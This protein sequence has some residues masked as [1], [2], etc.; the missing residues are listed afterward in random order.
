M[1]VH[2]GNPQ[3]DGDE[4]PKVE[5]FKEEKDDMEVDIKEDENEPELTFPYE[6][7]DPLNLWPLASDLEPEDVIEFEDTTESEDVTVPA[8]DI[9]SL[10]GRITSISRRLR[11]R[12]TAHA[13][14]EKKG[15]AKDKYY[16]KLILDLGNEMGSSVEEG[17]VAMKNLVR[18]LGN[19]EERAECN[20]LKKELEEARCCV[21]AVVIDLSLYH[22]MKSVDAAFAAERARHANARNNASGSR[23]ARGQVTAYVVQECIFPGFKK[24]N[25]DNFCGTEGAAEL[26]RWFEKMEMTFGIRECAKDKKVKFSAATLMENKLW[27]LKVMEYNMV[28]YTQRFIE[29]ALMCPRMI[30]PES[31]KIDVYIRGLSDNIKSEVTSSKPTNLNEVVNMTHKL[32]E[33][34]FPFRLVMIVVSKV[35]RGT[36]AQRRSRKRKL[37]KFMAKLTQLRM[38]S[39]K[40]VKHDATIVCGE[41]VVRIP[42]E[43]KTLT[44]ESDNDMSQLK[45][46]YFIKARK[47]TIA[48][49]VEFRIDLVPGA[50]PVVRALYR[51]ALP[52]MREFSE[53][54]RDILKKGFIRPSLSPWGAPVLF[55]KRK[56]GTFRMRSSV[57]SKIDLRSGY[58]QLRIKEEDIPITVFRI[59]YGH[60]EFQVMPFGLKNVSAVFMDLMNRV[61]K[62]YLDMF[63]IVFIDDIL[64]YSKDE[65]EHG[66]HVIDRN[67]VHVDPAKIEAIRNWAAPTTPTKKDKK[68]EWGMEEDEAFYRVDETG[69]GGG[70]CFPKLKTHEENYTTYDL[71][72]GV[73][74][75]VLGYG[76]VICIERTQKEAIKKKNVK[77]EKLGRLIKQIFEFR[78]DRTRC[79]GNHVWLLR[80]GGLRDLIMHESH[81]SKYSIHPGSDKMYQD[82]KLLYWW[83]NMKVDISVHGVPILIISDRDNHFTSRFWTSLQKALRINLD[84]SVAYHPQTDGQNKR[85]IQILEDMLCTCV[86]DFGSSWD[87]H[88]SLVE[89]LYNN[90]YHTSIKAASYEALY[91]RKLRFGKRGKLSPHYIGP[92]KILARVGPVAYTL[93]LPEEL[94]GIHSTFHV[95]N[96]KKCLAEGDIVI[97]MDEIQLDDNLYMTEEPVEIVNREVKVKFSPHDLIIHHSGHDVQRGVEIYVGFSTCTCQMLHGIFRFDGHPFVMMRFLRNK[98]EIGPHISARLG[99]FLSHGLSLC[100]LLSCLGYIVIALIELWIR[101]DHWGSSV[102]GIDMVIK[103]LDL[104]PKVGAMMRDF[105]DIPLRHAF[106]GVLQKVTLLD[107]VGTS[108]C[109]CGVLRSSRWKE[110]SKEISSKILLYGDGSC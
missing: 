83:L 107:V 7:A 58:H 2:A 32:M 8:S 65:E 99:V 31:V 96:L 4:D 92:F 110:L 57:Y 29:L 23:P 25:P 48:R 27:N 87:R 100:G 84:M 55:V 1:G 62:P 79:F 81:K 39:R 12:E 26:R 64:V 82:L 45:V 53:Q 74:V 109:H 59:R 56:D 85:T 89:F 28:A 61:C 24:C 91:R 40:L 49:Q 46:I 36:D 102:G 93:E 86:I 67:G 98:D 50:T 19:V 101:A 42:Y 73:V 17:T 77:A 35:I 72:L 108:G 13:L 103:D 18:K 63:V 11:G 104:E 60:F 95:L 22:V 80:F 47:I 16:G 6:E 33:Q 15:N 54:L 97:L 5:E 20:K 69:K 34:K 70:V 52:E 14:V 76:D 44:V 37:K 78:P 9:D 106:L 71:E 75:F 94:K 88:L 41:N 68:Y 30:D 51:L 66:N 43:N 3:C 10:F 90:S 21:T 105:F 38:L